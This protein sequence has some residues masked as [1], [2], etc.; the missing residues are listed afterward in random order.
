M[1][2]QEIEIEI[3][4]YNT[5][6]SETECV[7]TNNISGIYDTSGGSYEYVIGNYNNITGQSG[8]N[9]LSIPARY[10]DIYTGTSAITNK[11]LGDATSETYYWYSDFYDIAFLNEYPWYARNRRSYSSEGSG[12]F[13]I[14]D[15]AGN[16]DNDL[17]MRLILSLIA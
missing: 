10:K 11:I 4:D 3:G 6:D 12:L 17:S 13:H 14:D 2:E 9:I 7:A 5:V 8:L 16:A 1:P 15:M